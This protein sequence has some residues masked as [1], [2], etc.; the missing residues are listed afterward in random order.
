MIFERSL[1]NN[2]CQ[3]S[4]Q[5]GVVALPEKEYLPH[6]VKLIPKTKLLVNLLLPLGCLFLFN[7]SVVLLFV[8][9]ETAF[10]FL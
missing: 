7:S 6:L 8:N 9:R 4:N 5:I 10:I 3:F 2:L 1:R